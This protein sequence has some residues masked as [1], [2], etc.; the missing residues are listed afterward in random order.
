MKIF[1][2]FII[3]FLLISLYSF[4]QNCNCES[5]FQWVKKTFEENDAGYQYVID[6]KGVDAYNSHNI[7]FLDKVK[8]LKNNAECAQEIYQ[9]L[10]FF[11]SGHFSISLNENQSVLQSVTNENTIDTKKWEAVNIDIKKFEKHLISKKE[12]DLEGIWEY[13]SYKIGIKKYDNEY[14]GF[15]IKSNVNEW[16]PNEI[17][18]KINNNLNS[19]I[20][21][22]QNKTSEELK[23]IDFY[24]KNYVFF[25]D[26][27]FKRIYPIYQTEKEISEF[28]KSQSSQ[29]PY[30][31]KIN[32]STL[33]LRIPSFNG[34]EKKAIDSVLIA[35]KLKLETTENL[36][37]DLRNN[38]GG[39]DNSY[40]N[41]IPYLYTN[42]IREVRT[43]LYSTKLN[44]SRM[45]KFYENYKKYGFSE[46]QKDDFKYAYDI[47]EKNLGKFVMLQG[48]GDGKIVGVQKLEKTLPFP[49]N[50]GII[51]NNGNGSTT[52]QFLLAA[53]QSKKVKLFGTTTMGVL[54]ISNMNFID[55]PCKEFKFGYSISKSLRIP[56]MA[57]DEK[58]IQPDYYIDKSIP[59]YDWIGY[60]SDILNEK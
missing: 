18:L 60:V 20:Y 46:E 29:K 13:G 53:K 51:I 17:K 30:I 4:A 33:F 32:N 36:I 59:E 50:V 16:K 31:E 52:E 27:L 5:N 9:W 41:I 22:L 58:G 49:K 34:T 43:E 55:S 39:N 10:K 45:L 6:K 26:M 21:F 11:R 35:N 7:I 37:I 3:L 12:T 2:I 56:E 54:D 1:K 24:G 44:N 48:G 47:L 14:K 19:G 42:P 8:N 40:A 28:L 25:N 15:I 23:R 38:G 57:I